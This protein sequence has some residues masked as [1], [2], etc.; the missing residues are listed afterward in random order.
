M[1]RF[2]HLKPSITKSYAVKQLLKLLIRLSD[3]FPNNFLGNQIL[4]VTASELAILTNCGEILKILSLS[5]NRLVI[6][7]DILLRLMLPIYLIKKDRNVSTNCN[8]FSVATTIKPYIANKFI[9]GNN[10]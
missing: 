5:N 8:S 4:L 3:R 7:N 2:L 10:L 9:L 1:F 6:K